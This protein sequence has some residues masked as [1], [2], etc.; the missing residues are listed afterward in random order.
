M[1]ELFSRLNGDQRKLVTDLLNTLAVMAV[2]VG[3][4]LHGAALYI[5]KDTEPDDDRPHS[6]HAYKSDRVWRR[7]L[8]DDFL[9]RSP[10]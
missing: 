5:F 6:D 7:T 10:E 3:L 1:G 2:M 4:A 8:R 9:G